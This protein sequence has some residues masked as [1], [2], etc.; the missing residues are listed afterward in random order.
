[1]KK[2][3]QIAIITLTTLNLL[4]VPI[5]LTWDARP[6]QEQVTGYN[7]YQK[8]GTNYVKI[9]G[10]LTN[11]FVVD[12]TPSNYVFSMTATNFWGEGP[13]APD[14]TTPSAPGQVQNVRFSR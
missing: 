1:M 5:T 9:G 12:I 14:T 3:A 7:V 8:N 6:A 13:L 4:A 11:G 2:I 10:S